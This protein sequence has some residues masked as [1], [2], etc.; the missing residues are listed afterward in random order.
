MR[1]RIL[2]ACAILVCLVFSAFARG[3]SQAGTSAEGKP[4]I[5]VS[6]PPAENAWQ[7]RMLELLND[8][9]KSYPEFEW[10]VKNAVNNNDQENQLNIFMNDK[11]DLIV[12]LPG[13]GTLLR[14][15]CE[16]IYDSGTK[17]VIFD[18]PI[19]PSTKYTAMVVGDNYAGGVNGARYIGKKLN[20][21]GDVAVLRSYVGTPIDLDRYNGFADTLKKEYP[22]IRIIVEGDGEFNMNAGLKAMTDILNGYPKIDT[23]YAQDDETALGAL[24]A[25]QNARRSDIKFITGFGGKRDAYNRFKANDPVY[26]ASMSYLPILGWEAVELA[27]KV[28][29][30][31]SYEKDKILPSVAVDSS[32][33]DQYMQFSY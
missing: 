5:A 21:T 24:T 11:Y 3:G 9:I 19:S 12:I 32:N 4:R 18:R 27:V 29:K 10:T 7:A 1:K 8:R 15:T 16:R 33:V 6:L 30:G 23:V 14:T 2:C 20:G 26:V 13:D 22:G 17:T 28:L 25:I 31:E